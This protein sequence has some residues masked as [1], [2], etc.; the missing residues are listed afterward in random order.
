MM[1]GLI[2][3]TSCYMYLLLIRINKPTNNNTLATGKPPLTFSS[4][5]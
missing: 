2:S 5:N 4:E 1:T 3:D